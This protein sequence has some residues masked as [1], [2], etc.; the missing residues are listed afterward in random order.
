MFILI[1]KKGLTPNRLMP[2]VFHHFSTSVGIY[3]KSPTEITGG[4]YK[5]T[6]TK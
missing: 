4:T 1:F 5:E 2:L 6:Q 3:T